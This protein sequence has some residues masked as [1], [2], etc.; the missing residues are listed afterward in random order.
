MPE[1][2]T[3]TSLE[4]SSGAINPKPFS[5]DYYHYSTHVYGVR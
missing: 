4:P 5:D 1:K 3:K 2:C